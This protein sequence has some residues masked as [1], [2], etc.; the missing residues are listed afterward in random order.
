MEIASWVLLLK[1]FLAI[2]LIVGLFGGA[3][4]IAWAIYRLMP[5]SRLRRY[6]FLRSNGHGA[7]GAASAGDSGLK[8]APIIRRDAGK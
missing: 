3:K 6:L 2:A 7:N 1:P 8:D 5:D 4:L